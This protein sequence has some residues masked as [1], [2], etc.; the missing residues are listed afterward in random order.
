MYYRREEQETVKTSDIWTIEVNL[1]D[2][3]MSSCAWHIED[4][5]TT[6][7]K[8]AKH[9]IEKKKTQK[10]VLVGLANGHDEALQKSIEIQQIM[11]LEEF[12]RQLVDELRKPRSLDIC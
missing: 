1:D 9:A 10:W 6:I 7:G 12:K 5:I 2:D 4:L 11:A 8:N 3:F